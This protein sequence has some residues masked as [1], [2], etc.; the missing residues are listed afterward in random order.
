MKNILKF[1]LA[2]MFLSLAGL[3]DAVH[4]QSYAVDAQI[5][6]QAV[7]DGTYNYTITLNNK[8]SSGQ[9]I[10]MFWFAWIPGYYSYDLLSSYPMV[11]QMPSGWYANVAYDPYAY[12]PDGYSIEFYNYYGANLAPGDSFTFG[13]NS[14]DSPDA[15]NQQSDFYAIP[16]MT[17][18][19][20]NSYT[21]SDPGY[22][23]VVTPAATPPPP[24]APPA[25]KSRVLAG[26]GSFQL[27]FTN[28]PGYTFTIL[29][30]TNLFQNMTNW[31]VL[32]QV[33]DAPPGSGSYQFT[34][35]GSKTNQ[36][37]RFYR[38]SWP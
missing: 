14:V 3:V 23:F 33:T 21:M 11:T 29:G 38:V 30:T 25:L 32:G 22:E 36:P 5:S 35:T 17:S 9:S 28:A 7:G 20:Y 24:P 6:N 8:N 15:L 34:D 13:F 12:Y 27:A 18:Y 37:R 1:T 2:S 16:T 31:T 4:A 19:V 26:N 10:G